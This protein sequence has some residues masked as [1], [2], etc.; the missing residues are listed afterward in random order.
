LGFVLL[1]RGTICLHA[2]AIAVGDRAIALL[3]PAGAGK[4]TTAAMFARLGNSILSEDVVPLTDQGNRFLIQPGYPLIRLW[5]RSVHALC[6]AEDAL[7]LLTPNW[8]KRYLNLGE[9]KHQFQQQPLPLTAV[10]ILGERR[11]DASAPYIEAVST[12]KGL[13]TLVANSYVTYMKDKFM[14][15]QEFEVLGR[16]AAS[17]ALRTVIPNAD[18]SYLPK[19]CEAILGDFHALTAS[20]PT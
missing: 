11:A 3:G 17:V 6:G 5:P 2:S 9:G 20:I 14:R 13:I 1:L 18:I 10:Y 12:G 7:P 4:S 19:L 8:D 15:E 16:V